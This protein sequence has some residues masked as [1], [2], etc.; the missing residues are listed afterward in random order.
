MGSS[1]KLGALI[2]PAGKVRLSTEE[3]GKRLQ[4]LT[5]LGLNLTEFVPEIDEQFYL[6]AGK[7]LDRAILLAQSLTLRKF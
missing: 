1:P 3:R 7:P 2:H 4:Q 6:T 5:E